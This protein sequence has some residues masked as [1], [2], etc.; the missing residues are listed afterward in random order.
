MKQPRFDLHAPA[1]LLRALPKPGAADLILHLLGFQ[2]VPTEAA[3][4]IQY[5]MHSVSLTFFA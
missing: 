4:E 2:D 1:L 5:A 3:R